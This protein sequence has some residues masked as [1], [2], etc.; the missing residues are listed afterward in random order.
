MEIHR[1]G[2]QKAVFPLYV[3]QEVRG[4]GV[5]PIKDMFRCASYATVCGNPSSSLDR[6]HHPP[7]FLVLQG[8]FMLPDA[9]SCQLVYASPLT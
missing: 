4:G 5:V 7:P 2:E 9:Y 6:E 3:G 1:E 8:K